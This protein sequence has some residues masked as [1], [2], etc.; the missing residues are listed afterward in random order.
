MKL[1]TKVTTFAA[2]VFTTAAV[3]ADA[4]Q[5]RVKCERRAD[6]SVIS[7]D[8]RNLTVGA[9]SANITS[10]ANSVDAALIHSIGDEVG[11]DF[12]SNQNDI[13]QGAVAVPSNFIQGSV[14][15]KILTADGFVVVSDTVACRTR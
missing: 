9:Y 12:A 14:T 11:F 13:A 2:L 6:R 5:I 7:V 10:G 8:G 15:A 1:I 4:A 3:A